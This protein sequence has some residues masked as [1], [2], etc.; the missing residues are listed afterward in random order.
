MKNFLK[1]ENGV[2]LISLAGV[3]IVMGIITT[4]LMYSIRDTNDTGKLTDLYSDIDNL[5]DKVSNYYATYGQIPAIDTEE[6]VNIITEVSS[7]V[8]SW[9]DSPAGANDTGRFLVLDLNAIENLTLN[10]GKEF[11]KIKN[12]I[13]NANYTIGNY[14]DFYIINENSHNI[15]YLKGVKV[16]NKYYY[17]NQDKDTETVNLR[18][19]DGIKIPN[20]YNY[21]SGNKTTG[22]IITDGTKQYKYED[23]IYK[24]YVQG[25]EGDGTTIS[26]ELTESDERAW[27]LPY[28]TTTT[29]KDSNGDTCYIPAG[30]MV[31][32][33]DGMNK[34]NR[35]LVIKKYTPDSS[36]EEGKTRMDYGDEY[37]WISVPF[38][39]MKNATIKQVDLQNDLLV[40]I[41]NAYK[42]IEDAL[43]E[44][45]KDYR[46]DG[47]E[48]EWYDGCG[49]TETEYYKLKYKMYK[50]IYENGGFYVGRYEAGK[51]NGEL[52]CLRDKK[53]WQTVTISQAQEVAQAISS[54]NNTSLM[55][56]V[57]WNLILKFIE[58]TGIKTQYDIKNN[59][60]SWG[61]YK[62]TKS[63]ITSENAF[64]LTT[65]GAGWS[66]IAKGEYKNNGYSYLL[67]TGA[68]EANQVINIYDLSGNDNE[69]LLEK[70]TISGVRIGGDYS[71]D[72]GVIDRNNWG[73]TSKTSKVAFRVCL[74]K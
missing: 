31:S 53:P 21:L 68:C 2:T 49:L 39:V 41:K 40:D 16:N 5:T 63:L 10:Y 58:E 37:V 28:E 72:D 20:G 11:E 9:Q 12:N 55:F 22:I 15:F 35:G 17:T 14:R 1:Q 70:S 73:I 46:E 61:N 29:Y 52:V 57:Q 44:Y 26:V 3:I 59:S 30:F 71:S 56:G 34:I 74:F 7:A 67:T 54:A 51:E 6:S 25:G 8:S 42:E 60:T 50:S 4:M 33:L 47:Y 48:D 24:N 43:I 65:D 27:S 64:K 36:I 23:G 66:S 62:N 13:N 38:D 18:Y 32:K 19:V 69:I 45:T